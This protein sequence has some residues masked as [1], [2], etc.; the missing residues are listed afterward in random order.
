ME[1]IKGNML[2]DAYRRQVGVAFIDQEDEA[3]GRCSGDR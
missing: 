1:V 3:G 2:S